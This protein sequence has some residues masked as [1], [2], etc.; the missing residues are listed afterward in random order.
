MTRLIPLLFALAPMAQASELSV[1]P[2]WLEVASEAADQVET[3]LT[4]TLDGPGMHE[5]RLYTG[6][7][8]WEGG[9]STFAP[10]GTSRH[11][12]DIR[13]HEER[14]WVDAD[15]PARVP[16]TISLP[17]GLDAQYGVVFVEEVVPDSIQSE[18]IRTVS[19]IAV[20][21]LVAGS[22]PSV[23]VESVI[24]VQSGEDAPLEVRLELVNSGRTHIKTRFQGALRAPDGSVQ[25]FDGADPRFLMPGQQRELVVNGPMDL[26]PGDY[27]LLGVLHA[28][29]IDPITIDQFIHIDPP[30]DGITQADPIALEAP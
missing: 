11:S 3:Q 8:T 20:P 16:L 1:T 6:D 2:A 9:R 24:A 19:R 10:L 23:S 12:A 27:Q 5:V 18:G 30:M 14:V 22:Q 26:A 15:A 17:D 7:W 28:T 25:T 4:I 13:V 29:D 21:V